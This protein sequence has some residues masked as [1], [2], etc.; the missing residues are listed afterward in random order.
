MKMKPCEGCDGNGEVECDG[1]CHHCG[2]SCH[3]MIECE[4]C[5]STGEVEDEE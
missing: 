1:A 2:A 5:N 4:E 3:E